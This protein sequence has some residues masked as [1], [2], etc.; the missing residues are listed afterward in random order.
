[1][2]FKFK[3]KQDMTKTGIDKKPKTGIK[4]VMPG[5]IEIQFKL[6]YKNQAYMKIR[7]QIIDY[8]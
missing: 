8:G 2:L 6:K 1:M 7:K 4:S 3:I 5:R